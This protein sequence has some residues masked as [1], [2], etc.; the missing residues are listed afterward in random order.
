MRNSGKSVLRLEQTAQEQDLERFAKVND[1]KWT[2]RILNNADPSRNE[3]S[4]VLRIT[5]PA[6]SRAL[7]DTQFDSARVRQCAGDTVQRTRTG[8]DSSRRR[9]A[10]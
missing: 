7:E 6:D 2:V 4:G 9:M 10:T 5:V 1:G 8:K 3:V